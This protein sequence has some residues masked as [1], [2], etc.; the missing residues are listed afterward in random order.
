MTET[1]NEGDFVEVE[2]TGRIKEGMLI[3]DTTSA[4]VAEENGIQD[5]KAKYG[6]V[7]VCIG[8]GQLLKG[9]DKWIIGKAP[10]NYKV[11]FSAEDGF[12][13]KNAKLLQLVPTSKFR[14]QQIEPYPGLQVNIDGLFGL[15]RTVSGGRTVVDF[16]H[17]L[18]GKDLDYEVSVKRIVTDTQEKLDSL[19]RFYFREFSLS[20]SDGNAAID[21]KS[22]IPQQ[23]KEK[24]V[25]EIL[26]LIPEIK[27]VDF[28]VKA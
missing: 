7:I 25:E 18:A 6:P 15:V 19:L 1:I 12:G 21:L 20:L 2:Y 5:P 4:K 8:A 22:D 14:S 28:K 27:A 13:K 17:P 16:N 3:F 11:E 23:I 24:L 26:R 10:G 9:L